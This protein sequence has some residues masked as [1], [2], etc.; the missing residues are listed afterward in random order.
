MKY[1]SIL[2]DHCQHLVHPYCNGISKTTLHQLGQLA[3]NW[4]CQNC[5][6]KIYPNFLLTNNNNHEMLKNQNQ[7]EIKNEFVTYNDC[8]V[9]S[10]KV[11]GTETLA[12]S[13][14]NH[15][16]HKKCIGHF[17]NRSEY[18][19]F[20]VYY[21][22]KS[23]DCPICTSEMLPFTFLDNDE[24]I[25]LLLDIY[26]KPTYLNND[27]IKNVY[28]KLKGKD[29]FKTEYDNDD[30]K[31]KYF[32]KIDPDINFFFNDSCDYIID[33]DDII[34]QQSSELNMLTFNII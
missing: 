6:L 4:Y 10:K 25:M 22:S 23:W 12:C 21:S 9:C 8:S 13:S 26:T 27:N 15:W 28:I 32:D 34:F 33:T 20:L 7:I 31:D 14:C 18:Q 5:N 2:C 19:N 24:F 30:K 3:E 17:N 11:T 1:E 16:V 29:F